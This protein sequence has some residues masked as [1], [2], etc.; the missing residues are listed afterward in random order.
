M[1][2]CLSYKLVMITARSKHLL[3]IILAIL[4]VGISGYAVYGQLQLSRQVTELEENYSSLA[5]GEDDLVEAYNEVLFEDHLR[6]LR[7][8]Q[9]QASK[10]VLEQEYNKFKS[11]AEGERLAEIEEVYVLYQETIEKLERNNSVG[12]NTAEVSDQLGDWGQMF[13]NQ[14]LEQLK[15]RI[16]SAQDTLNSHYE[17]YLAALPTPSPVPTQAPARQPGAPA[18][19]PS[20]YSFQTVA[21]ER[22]NFSVYLVKMRLS[23]VTVKTLA[24]N[25]GDCD[26]NCPAKSLAQYIQ[27]NDAYAGIHG[28]YFC[29]PDYGQCSDKVN[30]YDFALFDSNTKSWRNE[31]TLQWYKNGL[32]AF[33]GGQHLFYDD[34]QQYYFQHGGGGVT[35]AI[36]NF[37]SLVKDG[38][39]IVDENELDNYQRTGK[40]ARGAI[41]VD[42]TY[43]YLAIGTGATVP[44]MAYVMKALG[45]DHA[46]NLDGGGSSALYIDGAYKVGPGRSLPNA[47]VLVRN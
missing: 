26:N 10:E 16:Q 30:S 14:E 20:G 25:E 34:I 9:I 19:S 31:H 40:G 42:D 2:I 28:T 15:E 36:S 5:Q 7:L 44:D 18:S 11:E 32:A 4:I 47:V 43:I 1:L 33:N 45:A 38:Q 12:I 17:Q 46:L 39:V 35:A 8:R 37:P 3:S 13:L 22:G 41:G 21:T 6:Y 29:P 27:E 24:A 23:E